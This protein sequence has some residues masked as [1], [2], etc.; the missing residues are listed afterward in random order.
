V[1]LSLYCCGGSGTCAGSK[2]LT[3]AFTLQSKARGLEL[4]AES[5]EDKDKWC[6][7]I[8]LITGLK[9]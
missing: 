4:E 8:R 2:K 5:T 1:L 7:A 9:S 6:A 3:H